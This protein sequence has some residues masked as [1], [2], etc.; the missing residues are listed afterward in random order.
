MI[1]MMEE[2]NRIKDLWTGSIMVLL[3]SG[4]VLM[5]GCIGGEDT[6]FFG[7]WGIG[8]KT[9]TPT[10]PPKTIVEIKTFKEEE[11]DAVCTKGGKP[12]I[13]LFSTTQCQSCMWIKGTYDKVAKEYINEGKIVA[14]HWDLKAE[15]DTLT[16]EVEG[17]VPESEMAVYGQFSPEGFVPTFVFGCRYY[18]VGAGYEMEG[19]LSKEEDEFRAVIEKLIEESG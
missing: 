19:N 14:Y 1:K 13:R 17:S 7:G 15:D 4:A 16:G 8:N 3:L 6:N 11:E 12:I 10:T 9:T 2:T 5:S 18:R